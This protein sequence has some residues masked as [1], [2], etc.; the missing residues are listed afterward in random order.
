MCLKQNGLSAPSAEPPGLELAAG[1]DQCLVLGCFPWIRHLGNPALQFQAQE[2]IDLRQIALAKAPH[3]LDQIL[4]HGEASR[5]IAGRS[6]G[7][8]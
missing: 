6:F 3:L 8:S 1:S 7:T 2:Q 4:G 5:D